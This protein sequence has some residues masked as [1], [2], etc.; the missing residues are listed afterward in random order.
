MFRR[1]RRALSGRIP[2]GAGLLREENIEEMEE[3][4][5]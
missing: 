4:V 3:G 5:E 1:R 2:Q